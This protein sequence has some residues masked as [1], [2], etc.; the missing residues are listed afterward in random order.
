[1]RTTAA[2]LITALLLALGGSAGA[3][4]LSAVQRPIADLKRQWVG[5]GGDSL[6]VSGDDIWLTDYKAGTLSRL[7]IRAPLGR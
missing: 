5:P 2:R 1:V 3:V 6:A 7:S 4:D